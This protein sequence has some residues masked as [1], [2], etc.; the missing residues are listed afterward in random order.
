MPHVGVVGGGGDENLVT[1][2]KVRL[3]FLQN[4]IFSFLI[5]VNSFLLQKGGEIDKW[6]TNFNLEQLT[7]FFFGTKLHTIFHYNTKINIHKKV[8]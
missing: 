5:D 7:N 8:W 1:K 3:I 6:Q 4:L 2:E